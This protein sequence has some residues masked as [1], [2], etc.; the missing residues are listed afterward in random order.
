[1]NIDGCL[2]AFE[3]SVVRSH[4]SSPC[5]RGSV[6][7]EFS[8][9]SVFSVLTFS[10]KEEEVALHGESTHRLCELAGYFDELGRARAQ[11]RAADRGCTRRPIEEADGIDSDFDL[12][13]RFEGER[14][15]FDDQIPA[16][17]R[18]IQLVVE[19]ERE[20]AFSCRRL[21]EDLLGTAG[22][23]AQLFGRANRMTPA[24]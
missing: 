10:S 4:L 5:L 3:Q 24:L 12:R 22:D 20:I 18:L 1:M 9:R 6:A 2:T 11:E 17:A 8:V 16:D 7:E 19:D 15:Y 23:E 21:E 14:V 13:R